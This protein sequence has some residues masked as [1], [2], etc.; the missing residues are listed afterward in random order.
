MKACVLG[1]GSIGKR[2]ASNLSLLGHEVAFLRTGKGTLEMAEEGH[3]WLE[4]FR[5]RDCLNWKPDF[6]IVCTPTSLH[7][8]GAKF[9]L[10]NG[11]HVYVEKPLA[12]TPSE[13]QELV[14]LAQQNELVLR[15]GYQMRFHE[16]VKRARE[17]TSGSSNLGELQGFSLKWLSDVRRWHPWEDLANSYVMRP[18]LGGGAINTLS[19]EIDLVEFLFGAV[20]S[21]DANLVYKDS[22][23]VEV[24]VD[25]LVQTKGGLSGVVQLRMDTDYRHRN[26]TLFFSNSLVEIDIENGR[27][28]SLGLVENFGNGQILNDA[29]YLTSLQAFIDD[30]KSERWTE[31]KDHQIWATEL[32]L[33][34]FR[35]A[36]QQRRR[37]FLAD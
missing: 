32:L 2:H 12:G 3:N 6:L 35:V 37:I 11:M 24:G 28:L 10:Q 34:N 14:L 30:V 8:E 1:Y 22:Q 9:G 16:L 29:S 31:D 23:N 7:I 25:A 26:I 4:F 15:V 18:E 20:E 21:V 5:P 17:L 13:I 33:L 36:G 27:I 19:H